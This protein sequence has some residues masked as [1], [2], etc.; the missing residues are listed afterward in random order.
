M[1]ACPRD[2]KP[3][4]TRSMPNAKSRHF[5]GISTV[6][7]S[8]RSASVRSFCYPTIFGS[9]QLWA[10]LLVAWLSASPILA[11]TNQVAT[12][13][14]PLNQPG[15]SPTGNYFFRKKFTIIKP[16]RGELIFH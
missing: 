10:I 8:Y 7:E 11:Q 16:E 4:Q 6:L 3:P 13:W 9:W 5:G 1:L 14:S 12:I 2:T 15:E